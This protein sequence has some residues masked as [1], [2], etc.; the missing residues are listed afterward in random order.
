MDYARG[1]ISYTSEH[2]LQGG[3]TRLLRP[4]LIG[5]TAVLLVMIGALALALV[6]RPMVS[7]DVSKDRGLFRENSQGQIE[8]AGVGGDDERTAEQRVA[9]HQLQDC[10]S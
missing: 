3:K 5:Y 6:E 9:E 4:R 1:L 10:R 2:E 8:C 7:L